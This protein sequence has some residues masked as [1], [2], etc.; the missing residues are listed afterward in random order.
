MGRVSWVFAN[1]PVYDPADFRER[2][3]DRGVVSPPLEQCNSFVNNRGRYP[4]VGRL[5]MTRKDIIEIGQGRQP[6][7][8][9]SAHTLTITD[10]ENDR[11]LRFRRLSIVYSQAVWPHVEQHKT[12]DTTPYVVTVADARHKAHLS[13]FNDKFNRWLFGSVPDGEMKAQEICTEV[14]K[15]LKPLFGADLVFRVSDEECVDLAFHGVSAWDAF[16]HVLNM[17]GWTFRVNDEGIP[18]VIEFDNI[19]GDVPD[20]WVI[21]G[22]YWLERPEVPKTIVATCQKRDYQWL[23]YQ[24]AWCAGDAHRLEP[25]YERRLDTAGFAAV[26]RLPDVE[27]PGAKV[28]VHREGEQVVWVPIALMVN[29]QNA[30]VNESQVHRWMRRYA[31]R[32]FDA[33]AMMA[34]A[35]SYRFIGA[36]DVL[37]NSRYGSVVY[38]D[39]GQGLTTRI[40]SSEL[41]ELSE[42]RVPKSSFKPGPP[43]T[44]DWAPYCREGWVRVVGPLVP[45]ES[46]RNTI[47][48]DTIGLASLRSGT[49]LGGRV[50]WTDTPAIQM[51]NTTGGALA[52]GAVAFAR[53]NYQI[54]E[55]GVWCI[56]GGAGAVT[57][58]GQAGL[59]AACVFDG[60]PTNSVPDATGIVL[61]RASMLRLLVTG[62]RAEDRKAVID[63][64][65]GP[66]QTVL[67]THNDR[68]VWS[69]SPKVRNVFLIRGRLHF[70]ATEDSGSQSSLQITRGHYQFEDLPNRSHQFAIAR[71]VGPN[72][73]CIGWTGPGVADTVE[74]APCLSDFEKQQEFNIRMSESFLPFLCNYMQNCEDGKPWWGEGPQPNPYPDPSSGLQPKECIELQFANGLLV[75]SPNGLSPTARRNCSLPPF[76]NAINFNPCVEGSRE[77]EPIGGY[78]GG[79]YSP[80]GGGDIDDPNPSWPDPDEVDPLFDPDQEIDPWARPGV[81]P[82]PA[83]TP[84]NPADPDFAVDPPE[85]QPDL[86][87]VDPTGITNPDPGFEPDD[88]DFLDDPVEEPE[89][90]DSLRGGLASDDII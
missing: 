21:D 55:Q 74:V 46:N 73:V 78:P 36:S 37:P 47:L 69:D 58:A 9:E 85:P 76:G 11:I 33:V 80:G 64:Q 82:G 71:A 61:N 52:Q 32:W 27:K 16:W 51:L 48:P 8:Q 89:E 49:L 17:V 75:K 63:I 29:D 88:T 14:W 30:A 68:V 39:T 5:L 24:G 57:V 43:N 10:E 34:R 1:K 38:E 50:A 83:I 35:T 56:I 20:D 22:D 6:G 23:K 31:E 60:E 53:W 72:S 25:T 15:S 13:A 4:S 81:D 28:K 12:S 70:S 40:N 87:L 19:K 84:I 3:A 77:G 90:E 67:H 26:G 54:G 62:R 41:D 7:R 86:G 45:S 44:R 42:P 18:E 65:Q 59:E 2:L 79:G 66:P